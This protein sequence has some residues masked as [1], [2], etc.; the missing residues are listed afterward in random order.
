MF[1]LDYSAPTSAQKQRKN[2]TDKSLL[3]PSAGGLGIIGTG[4]RSLA[5]SI[6][7]FRNPDAEIVAVFDKNPVRIKE[8]FR[9]LSD[10]PEHLKKI[11]VYEKETDFFQS[12]LF[13]TVLITVPDFAHKDVALKGLQAGKG[14]Y[15][16]KPMA[17]NA[18][19]AK[20]IVRLAK[21]K[22]AFLQIG[23]VLRYTPF[24]RKVKEIVDSGI[25]GQIIS[26]EAGEILSRMH[27]A[28][29]MRRWH[30]KRKNSGSLML[31]KCSHDLDILNWLVGAKATRVSSFGGLNFFRPDPTKGPYCSVCDPDIKRECPYV[32]R[33]EFVMVPEEE[34][35]NY[36][37][38]GWDLCVFN[39]D[40]DIVDN[41]ISLIEYENGVRGT[42]LLSAFGDEEDNRFIRIVG[43]RARLE[44]H[45][46][47]N[48][49]RVKP[50]V[51][52]GEILYKTDTGKSGHGGGDQKIMDDLILCLQGKKRPLADASSGFESTVVADAI[53]RAL[54]S[55]AVSEIDPAAYEF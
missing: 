34:K 44:G 7:A 28:S 15:L 49:I 1:K 46:E 12:D 10:W 51:G 29:Y 39:D 25:L 53:D 2:R 16:E 14:I 32:F 19:D 50:T 55:G 33:E 6:A 47:G 18:E 9:R 20:A 5:L 41:Q 37:G 13:D 26:I 24:Y 4:S 54:I 22:E 8:Y 38:N 40:K 23:F 48:W 11:R 36:G 31:T 43:T 52:D 17:L 21:K 27:G 45:F 30:R 42:F 35:S 3:G